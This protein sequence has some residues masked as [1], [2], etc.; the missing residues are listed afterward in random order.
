VGENASYTARHTHSV[1]RAAYA[2][3]VD[4]RAYVAAL[5]RDGSALA[6]AADGSLGAEI[7]S[8][9]GWSMS[10]L[11]WHTLEVHAFWREI[12]ARRLTDR[13]D[14]VEPGRP[15]DDVLVE[16]F[17][18]GL[19]ALADTLAH[20]DVETP[21]WTWSH[22]RNAGFVVRRMAQETAVHRW[23]AEAAVG[24]QQRIEPVLAVDGIDEWLQFMLPDVRDDVDSSAAYSVHLHCTDAPGEWIVRVDGS[25]ARVSAEHG[26]ADVAVRGG[27]SEL[28]LLLW[29]RLDPGAVEVLGDG[30]VLE[31]FLERT[32]LT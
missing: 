17:R 3:G 7:E 14:V 21:L 28:L 23:D 18:G 8:C 22:Q 32:D 25:D 16:E 4:Q 10:D 20:V 30:R 1:D 15:S 24:R 31:R 2:G 26:K 5:R 6:D 19:D 12:V 9:P 13:R 29:R 27:A 11:V